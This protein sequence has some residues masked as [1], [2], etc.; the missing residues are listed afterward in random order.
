MMM[1]R[2]FSSSVQKAA[3]SS[4]ARALAEP[5]AAAS[6][7]MI[8]NFNT[9]HASVHNKKAVEQVILPG[10][11]GVYGI[12][13]GHSPIISQLEPGVVTVIHVGGAIDK[14]FVPGGFAVTQAN[15]VTD[16]SVPEAVLL[17][18]FEE[19][20]IRANNAEA[21]QLLAS[22]AEGSVGKATATIQLSVNSAIARAL[23]ITL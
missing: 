8:I 1:R 10:A 16:I 19:S 12:T 15:S 23:N 22:S 2:V 20:H 14:Y 17:T 11:A 4:S 18:D 3:Y 21:V 5:A 13:H 9:P 7:Q 6:A